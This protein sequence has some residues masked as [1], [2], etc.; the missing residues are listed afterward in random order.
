MAIFNSYVRLPEGI[1]Q[2]SV[3]VPHIYSQPSAPAAIRRWPQIHEKC[4]CSN[5]KI[6]VD[7]AVSIWARSTTRKKRMV[8]GAMAINGL[9]FS[10]CCHGVMTSCHAFAADHVEV[11]PARCQ[12]PDKALRSL[13]WGLVNVGYSR[14]ALESSCKDGSVYTSE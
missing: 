5:P 14:D 11:S 3:N 12:E 6:L 8:L 2:Q 1:H 13:G 4:R 7:S 9:W 10:A